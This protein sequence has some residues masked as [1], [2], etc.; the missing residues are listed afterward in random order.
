[1]LD[2][3]ATRHDVRLDETTRRTLLRE[4]GGH[5]GLLLAAF[6]TA[7]ERPDALSRALRSSPRILDECRRIWYSLPPD[8][9]QVVA[10]LAAA[11]Q[12][13]SSAGPI[14]NRLKNKG[15][16]TEPA[17]FKVALF[18]TLFGD[19]LLALN[20]NAG[21]QIQ[22]DRKRRVV[23][24]G[25]KQIDDLSPLPFKLLDYLERHRDQVCKRADLTHYLYPDEPQD[26]HTRSA[27]GRLD[28]TVRRLR[29]AIEPDPRDPRY[30]LTV[31]GVGYQLANN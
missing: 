25:D 20:L 24:V 9:Q 1:M 8:E 6:R 23:I 10:A 13:S 5:S 16:V 11:P 17:P 29:E 4:T 26:D 3:L 28:T 27:D 7:A 19:C 14:L 15:L 30:I 22:V 2:G 31:R 12:S 18:S 21:A